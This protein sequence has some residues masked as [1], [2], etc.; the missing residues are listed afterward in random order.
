MND[1]REPDRDDDTGKGLLGA[2]RQVLGALADAEREGQSGVVGGG[3]RSGDRV[4]VEYGFTG[5]LGDLIDETDGRRPRASSRPDTEAIPETETETE[6]NSTH[7]LDVREEEGAFLVVADVAGVDVDDL[8]VGLTD[9]RT[10]LVV[11]VEDEQLGRIDLP[12]RAAEVEA[13]HQ[14]GVL[15]IRLTPEEGAG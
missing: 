2:I 1:D 9:E 7:L 11:L 13:Q 3:K 10:T 4:S 8:T 14:H 5:R 12:W 6:T 15:E